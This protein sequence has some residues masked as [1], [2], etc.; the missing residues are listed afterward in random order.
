MGEDFGKNLSVEERFIVDYYM[1]TMEEYFNI[2]YFPLRSKTKMEL[3]DAMNS[4]MKKL[5]P[6]EVSKI[7]ELVNR[8]MNLSADELTEDPKTM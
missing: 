3:S 7:T 5:S 8:G 2:N 4:I 6:E 1:D